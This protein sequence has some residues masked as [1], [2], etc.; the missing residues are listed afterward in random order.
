MQPMTVDNDSSIPGLKFVVEPVHFCTL[1]NAGCSSYTACKTCQQLLA[2]SD[3]LGE[4]MCVHTDRSTHRYCNYNLTG[5][6]CNLQATCILPSKQCSTFHVCNVWTWHTTSCAGIC[7]Q[8]HAWR[9]VL[10]GML[11]SK[12]RSDS[13]VQWHT[14]DSLCCAGVRQSYRL[15]LHAQITCEAIGLPLQSQGKNWSWCKSVSF[16]PRSTTQHDLYTYMDADNIQRSAP[17]SSCDSVAT[18]KQMQACTANAHCTSAQVQSSIAPNRRTWSIWLRS[19]TANAY[20]APLLDR[21]L[22]PKIICARTVQPDSFDVKH[23]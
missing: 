22:I 17:T 21:L 9:I 1:L 19:V 23:E 6:T 11:L 16:I 18:S 12:A 10:A 3:C 5:M 20:G 2:K 14:S 15:A 4:S 8:S 13:F 7:G